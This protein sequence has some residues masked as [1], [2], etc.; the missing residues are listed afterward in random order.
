MSG[1][2]YNTNSAPAAS[3][4]L[5]GGAGFTFEDLVVSYYLCALLRDEGAFG[6]NGRVVSVAVQ[7]AGH[8]QPMDDLVVEFDDGG[9]VRTLGLQVKRRLSVGSGNADFRAVLTA[10]LAV[11]QKADFNPDN[12][13]YGFVAEF[14]AVEPLRSL[15]RLIEWAKAS[16][17]EA[18]FT[19]RFEPGG[20][21]AAAE[22]NMRA[23]LATIIDDNDH[24]AFL[25]QLVAQKMEGLG[26]GGPARADLIN[27]LRE[28]S[29]SAEL[30]DGLLLFDRLCRLVRE[31]EASAKKWTRATLLNDLGGAIPLKVSPSYTRDIEQLSSFSLSGLTAIPGD[32]EGFHVPRIAVEQQISERLK[33]H[34]L[35][36]ITGLPGCGK[37]VM[38]KN[39]ASVASATG[40]ILFLKSDQLVGTNWPTFAGQL[41]LSHPLGELLTEIGTKGTPILFIDGIDRLRTDQ[42]AIVTDILHAVEKQ[43]DATKWRVLASSRDQGLEPFRAW[44]PPS[45]YREGGMG[46]VTVGAFSNEEVETL[47]EQKPILRRLLNG[48]THVR[49]IARR[50]FFAAVMARSI[51]EDAPAPRTEV[52]LI[53]AWWARGGHDAAPGDVLLRQRAMLDVAECGVQSLGKNIATRSIPTAT[54]P[55]L[56]ALESD[57]IIRGIN[58]N[59][60]YSF[61][62]D[63][64][65]EWAFFRLLLDLGQDWLSAITRAGEPPLLGRVVGLLAQYSLGT[66]GEWTKGLRLLEGTSLRPQW[67]REWLTA[68][69]FTATFD[70]SSAEF[71]QFLF[72]DEQA[73]LEKVL[74]WF[75]AQH[76]TPSPVIL[77]QASPIDESM[78]KL[79]IADLLGWPSDFISWERFILWLLSREELLP[80]RLLPSV[81]EILDVWQ[82]ACADFKHPVSKLI[83]GRAERWLM[84]VEQVRYVD[85]RRRFDAGKWDPLGGESL[86]RFESS[87]RQMLLRAAR[88]FPEA[89]IALLDRAVANKAMREKAY[90]DLMGY[91]LIMSE[92]APDRLVAVAKA[93]IL[94][95]LP[96][97]RLERERR[98]RRARIERLDRI[99]AIPE[100]ERTPDQQKILDHAP[101]SV[102]FQSSPGHDEI[103]IDRLPTHYFPASALEQPFA[104]L[105]HQKPEF[106]L[107]LVKELADH[108]TKGWVQL[109]EL[110]GATPVPVDLDFPW[111]RQRFWGGWEVY[112]WAQGQLA[113]GPLECAFLALAHWAH[114][115]LDAGKPTDEVIRSIVEGCE[116]YAMAGLALT[117][118]HETRTVSDTTL[119]LM[120][121]QRLWEHDIARMTQAPMRDIEIP[122]FGLIDRLKGAK[123]EAKKYLAH[124]PSNQREVR[125][126]A[127]LFALGHDEGLREQFS[128]ALAQFPENLPF[129]FEEERG[130]AEVTAN[131]REKAERWAGLGDRTNYRQSQV[132]E[133]VYIHYD[134]P[135]GMSPVQQRRM[136]SA[137]TYLHE[138]GVLAWATRYLETG[139]PR[140]GMSLAEAVAFARGKDKP[141][142]FKQREDVGGHTAQSVVSAVAACVI[143]Y[144]FDDHVNF[145]WAF[146]VL[147]RIEKMKELPDQFMGSRIPWHPA[148]HLVVSFAELRKRSTSDKKLV[149]RLLLLTT[150]PFE[151]VA[152]LALLALLRDPDDSVSWVA[153]Q[154]AFDL[155]LS[156]RP[157]VR[158]DGRRDNATERDAHAK[159]LEKAKRRLKRD[160]IEGLDPLP[161][162]WAKSSIQRRGRA[163][164]DEDNWIDPD[165]FF[166]S[167]GVA[168]IAKEFPIEAWLASPRIRPLLENALEQWVQWTAEKLMPSGKGHNGRDRAAADTFEWA[169]AL[170]DILSRVAPLINETLMARLIGP[171][172]VEGDAALAV[173]ARFTDRL[174]CRHVLDAATVAPG[175]LKLL[176]A[177]LDRVLADRAF[178]GGW[179]AGEM[180][181]HDLPRMVDALLFVNVELAPGAAQFANGD[182]SQIDLIMPLVTKLVGEIGWAT[183]VASRFLTLCERAGISYPVAIFADQANVV[184]CSLASRQELWSGTRLPAR[185]ASV[186]QRLAEANY[187]LT[188]DIAQRLL[189]VLDGLV[190][191]GDRRSAA[192]E[193]SDAFRRV[194]S[195]GSRD[196]TRAQSL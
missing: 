52:D 108:A 68:P 159:A 146:D 130:D 92:V 5:A 27:R 104:A 160:V 153:A 176:D 129:E 169:R 48:D 101:M 168:D 193:Q 141:T 24:A 192:L 59:L 84:D 135:E 14:V 69:P 163:W 22:R 8:D 167:K 9:T 50:P 75:Q 152:K 158:R 180:Y 81:L 82:N 2:K 151:D 11:I 190:D 110:G 148:N 56:A 3:T 100:N 7:R 156:Y 37:S 157:I 61:A 41:G 29:A 35:V 112:S 161:P 73:L 72:A 138:Q 62:H 123:A 53:A 179:R 125:E 189:T 181:G 6:L 113:P 66:A 32:I 16:P 71:D 162:P 173:L 28:S 47:A 91:S 70:E 139:T 149:E 164:E 124:R 170:G 134:P 106:G 15:Q 60:S 20:A 147:R 36:N 34:R 109:R 142:L 184:L 46:D 177:C 42:K 99:R 39:I 171:F 132:Q 74:V 196:A 96:R 54:L 116:C 90:G 105:F 107:Q 121:C 175:T 185:M 178:Q 133:N 103:G 83:I 126:L 87:L 30:N 63:I 186:V 194:Q 49:Q 115:Q 79:R 89:A 145:D 188:P 128:N 40:P 137:T 57:R 55:Q 76:T 88:A 154:L 127:M 102:M 117:L 38:L 195:A 183:A 174:V 80:V 114:K 78:D 94:E 4:E 111:G 13:W 85:G 187:P 155:A 95:E 136:D 77:A 131:L 93:K 191:L 144:G 43:E 143:R 119:P 122:A 98:E 140:D 150:Y 31:G 51:P 182:W 120:M 33:A 165:P 44:F 45:F 26:D 23:D 97:D 166:Y 12:D 118:A 172:L 19:R 64:F 58:E 86:D 25:R 67:R 17:S 18:D 10:A 1:N 21:A 65:F